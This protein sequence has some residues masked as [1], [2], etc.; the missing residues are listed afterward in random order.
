MCGRKSLSFLALFLLVKLSNPRLLLN[1]VDPIGP[2][3]FPSHLCHLNACC[4]AV[5][6][7]VGRAA[8]ADW[9]PSAFGAMRQAGPVA[10][11]CCTDG[12]L[13][14]VTSGVLQWWLLKC[15]SCYSCKENL[16]KDALDMND[17]G[18]MFPG[19]NFSAF[20]FLTCS[21]VS[22]NPGSLNLGEPQSKSHWSLL[23]GIPANEPTRF[24]G[25]SFTP[26]I[27]H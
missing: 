1:K 24:S 9:V 27:F 21:N 10:S 17:V 11:C 5:H 3:S 22:Q 8:S 20:V 2:Q 18:F 25:F 7:S 26:R 16:Y 13:L 14:G 12:L 4:S 19:S 6:Q 15:L 23:G